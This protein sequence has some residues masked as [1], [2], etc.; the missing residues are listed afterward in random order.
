MLRRVPVCG[1]AGEQWIA[2]ACRSAREMS[3]ASRGNLK[4]FA[5]NRNANSAQFFGIF[6]CFQKTFIISGSFLSFFLFVF[7]IQPA[8]KPEGPKLMLFPP[9]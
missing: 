8:S 2:L 5:N 1:I 7:C 9:F 4:D 6:L 3:L